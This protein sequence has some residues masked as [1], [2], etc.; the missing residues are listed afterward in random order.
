[1]PKDRETASPE[2]LVKT[3]EAATIEL[4]ES[5]LQK[6]AGGRKA[7]ESQKDFLTVTLKDAVIIS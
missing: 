3:S 2:Q 4:S 5:E 6:V 7:G 1:M